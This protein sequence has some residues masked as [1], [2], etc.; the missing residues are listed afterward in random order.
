ME[1]E[2]VLQR[3]DVRTAASIAREFVTMGVVLTRLQDSTI[4]WVSPG[5]ESLLG[6]EPEELMGEPATSFLHHEDARHATHARAKAEEGT[7]TSGVYRL[8]HRDGHYVRMRRIAW[9]SGDDI[10]VAVVVPPQ[11]PLNAVSPGSFGNAN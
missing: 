5:V 3:A 8:R 10:V 4:L 1:I 6:Y 7:T 2:A 9:P 11:K